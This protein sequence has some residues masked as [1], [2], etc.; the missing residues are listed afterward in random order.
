VTALYAA[1]ALLLTALAAVSASTLAWMLYAW[2]TPEQLS[3][4]RFPTDGS[5][6]RTFSLIVPARHEAAVLGRTLDGLAALDHPA[7]E[8]V[9][10]VGD[11][12][13][14]TRASAEAAE[15]RHPDIVRV[16]TDA[17]VPKSKPRALNT[18]LPAC[19]GEV[20]GVFDA[21]D[22][23]HPD[24]LRKVDALLAETGAEMAQ[25]GVQLVDYW[26]SWYSV[27]SCLEYYFWFRSR[28][29]FHADERFI[30]LGGNTVFVRADLLREAGGW[31]PD[32]LAED[33]ELGVRLSARGAR[34]AVAYEAELATREETP[35][36]L[37]QLFRQRTRWHQGFLQVLRKGHW[38]R[39]PTRRQR[40]LARYTLAMPFLQA[41]TGVLIPL[42][43]L[44]IPLLEVPIGLALFSF[45][46]LVMTLVTLAV[47]VVGLYD[48]RR[49]FGGPARR[50]D[51]ARLVLGTPFYQVVLAGAA[52]RAVAREG[53]GRNN[54]EKTAHAGR[55]LRPEVERAG[56]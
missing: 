13:P 21:E 37:G 17:S 55:H 6:T 56:A 35:H 11:D 8:V 12:D 10:V 50:R 23:V 20:I 30:P 15:A 53:L 31:D 29:H 24:L 5:A 39:L 48:L 41:F 47:E 22:D 3:G 42:S 18:A 51:V 2:R 1:Y 7:Y 19:R 9:V 33:C 32:C 14:E 44:S 49:L 54:W 36:T 45:V 40:M 28:L 46:P 27:R 25:G 26:S 16:V 52:V 38:R 4:T 43:L 34:V